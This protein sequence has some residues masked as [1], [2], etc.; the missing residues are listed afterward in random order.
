MNFLNNPNLEDIV[1]DGIDSLH[2]GKGD[3]HL[4]WEVDGGN[5]FGADGHD[6]L[7]LT[8][9]AFGSQSASDLLADH[10]VPGIPGSGSHV[11]RLDLAADADDGNDES[12]LF[13]D[14]PVRDGSNGYGG[15]DRNPSNGFPSQTDDQT[16]YQDESSAT[17]VESIEH[18]NAT[19]LGAVDYFAAGTNDPDLVFDNQQNFL[20]IDVELDL[21]GTYGEGEE[22]SYNFETGSV[23]S[24]GEDDHGKEI[25][26][27]F[28]GIDSE[29]EETGGSTVY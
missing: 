6:T 11:V 7:W 24:G 15:A 28:E 18:V 19:G 1:N 12:G 27:W 17:H 4:V 2:G 5:Y 21:R 23:H 20:G 16:W 10:P 9:L 26:S 13:I 29:Y 25:A 22:K 8:E 14:N 3:D